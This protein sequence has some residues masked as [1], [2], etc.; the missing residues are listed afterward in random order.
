MVTRTAAQT[1]YYMFP[2]RL[3][4]SFI[5]DFAAH[6][7]ISANL[8]TNPD[9]SFWT[10]GVKLCSIIFR[11][12]CRFENRHILISTSQTPPDLLRS[13]MLSGFPEATF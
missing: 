4:W 3:E 13:R 7:R 8:I 5:C 1:N 9:S 2:V 6:S 11:C 10:A 12:A